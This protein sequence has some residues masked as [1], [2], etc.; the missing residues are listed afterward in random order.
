MANLLLQVLFAVPAVGVISI[1]ALLISKSRWQ[2]I[3]RLCA[4]LERFLERP[5]RGYFVVG[6]VAFTVPVFTTLWTGTPLPSVHDEFS[7]LLASDTFAHGRLTNTT[8]LFWQHY[9]TFH[10][11]MHPSYM[12]KYPPG[13]GL[14]LAIGQ[15]LWHPILGVWL[16]VVLASLAF[17]GMLR[18]WFAYRSRSWAFIGGTLFGL[19]PVVI[20]W[21][22]M[23]WGGC[24][25][26]LGGMLLLG[27]ARYLLYALEGVNAPREAGFL[28]LELQIEGSLRLRSV[29][30]HSL[31]MSAGIWILAN[32]RPFE[33][34]V[35]TLTV[36]TA[37]VYSLIKHSK[38][39]CKRTERALFLPFALCTLFMILQIG[40]YNYRVAGSPL[41]LPYLVHE[42][43]YGATPQLI[44]QSPPS[45]ISY[46]HK[47]MEHFYQTNDARQYYLL[48]T[49][50]G[51]LSFN[52]MKV[53]VV[54]GGFY[55][56]LTLILLLFTLPILLRKSPD[57]RFAT[58]ISSVAMLAFLFEKSHFIHYMAPVMGLFLYLFLACLQDCA[59]WKWRGLEFGKPFVLLW[60]VS[61]LFFSVHS[62]SAL[63]F[64]DTDVFSFRRSQIAEELKGKGRKHLI[65]VRYAE[66]HDP[67]R[68]W[69]YNEADIESASI[70]WAED[71]GKERNRTLLEHFHDR[72]VWI[73]YAD[74][75]SLPMLPYSSGK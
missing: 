51:F 73:L 58:L 4:A 7:Y 20:Y 74:E 41:T 49:P 47:R 1:I 23:Y 19:H 64:A 46:N 50:S 36:L 9:E 42:R 75:L 16:G 39:R 55:S 13:Q 26:A 15:V 6:C 33:G 67:N 17:Y 57:A 3:E 60:I 31:G 2:G 8:P 44:W 62:L 24:V 53:A 45:P 70:V 25:A 63:P 52:L 21:G 34:L 72:D 27:N 68:E 35:L 48:R 32:S 5:L 10:V 59:G 11:L 18:V 14:F 12:S 30:N 28:L 61:T 37:L 22:H 65:L 54:L 40:Y 71:M 38:P 43:T 66:T 69:V 56:P 29:C